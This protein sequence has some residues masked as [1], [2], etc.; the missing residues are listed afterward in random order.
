MI[1]QKM[2]NYS[3][4]SIYFL[5]LEEVTS[6]NISMSFA[7]RSQDLVGLTTP[8]LLPN[9]PK[10]EGRQSLWLD[11]KLI[12]RIPY[13]AKEDYIPFDTPAAAF[14]CIFAC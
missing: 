10:Q 11:E 4:G 2:I 8:A 9:S 6:V 13:A 14:S 5:I 1:N 12:F 7:T 3:K